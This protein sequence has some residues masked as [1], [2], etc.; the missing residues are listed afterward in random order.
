MEGG[1]TPLLYLR[2]GQTLRLNIDGMSEQCSVTVA[3]P[4]RDKS[5]GQ[6]ITCLDNP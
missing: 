3:A 4:R 1:F 6:I 5:M 2:P